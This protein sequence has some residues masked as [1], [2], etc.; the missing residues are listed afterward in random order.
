MNIKGAEAEVEIKKD[1]V[2]KTRPQKKYRHSELDNR[3]RK[4]RTQTEFS[5][6]QKARRNN[7]NVPKVEKDSDYILKMEKIDGKTLEEDFKVEKMVEVGENI[8]KLHEAGLIHGDLTT[9]NIMSNGEVTLIDF[10]LSEDSKGVEDRAVDLH[11]LKQILESSHPEHFE[12]AWENFLENYR[13]E[14][15]EKVLERLQEVE[16]RGRY[17]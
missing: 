4:Q 13:P 12:E 15:R 2:I 8:Q 5:S 14:F 16:E 6:M 17:K 1:E 7:V 10:G 9:K 11:L 3:I